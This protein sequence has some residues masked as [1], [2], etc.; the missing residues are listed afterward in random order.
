MNP[1][2]IK[3]PLTPKEIEKTAEKHAQRVVALKWASPESEKVIAGAWEAG[4]IFACIDNKKII[5]QSLQSLLD[6]RKAAIEDFNGMESDISNSI[7]NHDFA[8]G[9]EDLIGKI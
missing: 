4:Y 8:K 7:V 1:D 3:Q 6:A 2:Q 5:K 9:V